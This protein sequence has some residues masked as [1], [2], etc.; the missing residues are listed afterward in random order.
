M[1]ET[2]PTL[3]ARRSDGALA[4]LAESVGDDG[5]VVAHWLGRWPKPNRASDAALTSARC[6]H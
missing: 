5:N 3:V 2:L 1:I 4:A 6:R